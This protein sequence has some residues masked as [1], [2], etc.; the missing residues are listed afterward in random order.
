MPHA[1]PSPCA[2]PGCGRLT[3]DARCPEHARSQRRRYARTPRRMDAKR[4][5][6]G[7]RWQRVRRMKLA[8]HPVCEEPGCHEAAVDVHHRRPWQDIPELAFDLNNLEALCK[9]CHNRRRG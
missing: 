1:P 8:A 9:A 4:F 5:Y 6:A 3:H 2:E 7:A